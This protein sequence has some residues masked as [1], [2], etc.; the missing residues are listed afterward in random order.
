MEVLLLK[1]LALVLWTVEMQCGSTHTCADKSGVGLADVNSTQLAKILGKVGDKDV[2]H[3]SSFTLILE[4][5]PRHPKGGGESSR[6][7]R[8]P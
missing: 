3:T 6:A 8:I 4:Y 1:V 5:V 2:F 7:Q